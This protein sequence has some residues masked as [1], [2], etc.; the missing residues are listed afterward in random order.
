VDEPA[1]ALRTFL[2][3][4]AAG[5]GA[6]WGSFLN[7][8]IA[9]VPRGMSVV[10]PPSHCFACGARVLARDNIPILSYLLLRGRCR[11]CGAKFSARHALVEALTGVLSAL[12]LWHFALDATG[13][14]MGVRVARYAVYF[15]F[16]AVLLVLTFID[17]DTKRLPDIITLPSVVVFFL[18]GFATGEV[19][20]LPRLI[21]AAAG[22]LLVRLIADAYYYST[23]REGLGLGDGKL[24]AM[25]GALLGW[26]AL[27]PIVFSASFVG[28]LVSIPALVVQRRR[29]RKTST[30]SPA[31]ADSVADANVAANGSPE[32]PPAHAPAPA[33]DDAPPASIR[34]AEVP[35]GPFLAA[36]ALGYLFLHRQVWLFIQGFL[37]GN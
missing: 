23:G 10:R 26:K 35:F 2:L 1:T 8:C 32:M 17:L 28:I 25:M 5:F 6:L 37:L 15:A 19:D 18:G 16:A 14:P 33:Q 4:S 29:Q 11:H 30:M 12:V 9:R 36:S 21:G 34:K 7:V 20:W 27:M 31:T 3:V 13:L 22:Y 24:L